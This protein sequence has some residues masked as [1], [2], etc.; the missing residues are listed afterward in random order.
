MK[1]QFFKQNRLAATCCICLGLQV[2]AVQAAPFLTDKA[3]DL[4]VG[5]NSTYIT[6]TD[7]L[8][9]GTVSAPV[10]GTMATGWVAENLP[11]YRYLKKAF[12]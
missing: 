2:G 8:T 10:T 5:V 11:I 9:G 7:S 1:N 3:F 6:A 4:T 12:L